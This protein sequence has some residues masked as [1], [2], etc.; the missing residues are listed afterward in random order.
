[1]GDHGEDD[2]ATL[3]IMRMKKNLK[4]ALVYD[5]INKIGGAERVLEALHEIWPTA[6]IY[7]AVYNKNTAKWADMFR[8]YT[9]F[10]QSLPVARVHHEWFAWA[11]PMAFE[12][13]SFD[14]YDVVLSVTSA[15]AKNIITKPGTV[16]ICYCLTPTRYLWSGA[17]EYMTHSHIGLPTWLVKPVL[18]LTQTYLRDWDLIASTRPDYYLAISERVKQRIL[19]YYARNVERVIYPPVLIDFFTP[20]TD[21]KPPHHKAYFLIVSRLVAYKKVDQVIAACNQLKLPLV[22]IGNGAEE[23]YL[24]KMAGNTIQFIDSVTDVEL[25]TWVRGCTAFIFAGDEDFGISTVEAQSCGKPVIAYKHSGVSEIVIDG[26]TGVLYDEQTT[27][28]LVAALNT[29]RKQWYDST[30]CR[31]NAERFSLS[32]FKSEMKNAVETIYNTHI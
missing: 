2:A 16:H 28:G 21:K 1:M 17:S 24:K 11:T 13:F 9:S 19:T 22:V 25:R 20:S 18:S 4:V 26:V 32:R 30:L 27:E 15:E 23:T 29:F 10:L 31:R 14:E 3:P 5:R 7:T 8:V 6:P 12:R